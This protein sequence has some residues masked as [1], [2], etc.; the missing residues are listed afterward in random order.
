MVTQSGVR[1]IKPASAKGAQKN[2]DDFICDSATVVKNLAIGYVLVG[3]FGDS[4]AKAYSIP[5]LK[6]LASSS[7]SDFLDLMG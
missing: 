6:Q 4:C 1:I 2:W 3:L 5:A 7:V